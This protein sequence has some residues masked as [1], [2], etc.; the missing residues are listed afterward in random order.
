M[1]W[2]LMS[3]KRPAKQREIEHNLASLTGFLGKSGDEQNQ[4]LIQSRIDDLSS[5][6]RDAINAEER[7][8][9]MFKGVNNIEDLQKKIDDINNNL[10]GFSNAALRKM[11]LYKRLENTTYEEMETA[12]LQTILGSEEVQEIIDEDAY[13]KIDAFVEE[14]AEFVSKTQKGKKI[15]KS[16]LKSLIVQDVNEEK[17][18]RIKNRRLKGYQKNLQIMLKKTPKSTYSTKLTI[19]TDLPE[20]EWGNNI[21]YYPYAYLT[22]KQKQQAKD[23]GGVKRAKTI[24]E[25]FVRRLAGCAG[26]YNNEAEKI[27]STKFKP[28]DFFVESQAQFVGIL[29]EV[30][31]T[32]ILAVLVG[33]TSKVSFFGNDLENSKKIGVDVALGNVGFQVKNYNIEPW[34]GIQLRETITMQNFLNKMLNAS[35]SS[36]IINNLG[37]FYALR[38]YHV[39]ATE[40]F[41][42]TRQKIEQLSANI[43]AWLQSYSTAF[44]PLDT[45]HV[46]GLDL[47]NIFYF[48][49]GKRIV[50][51][52]YIISLYIDYLER[53]K[54]E[55]Y[56][57]N[58]RVS[59]FR[60]QYKGEQTYADYYAA[61][62]EL[63]TKH[64]VDN[65]V[66]YKSVFDQL[67][68]NVTLKIKLPPIQDLLNT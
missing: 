37:T 52:S 14:F 9:K 6:K 29:G 41:A 49:G 46:R 65:F 7:A 62:Q 26:K 34:E 43:S 42:D 16:H 17:T 68:M 30:Q 66:G 45:F 51:I 35:V 63:D 39:Q 57:A 60:P 15:Q 24:W 56:Q 55:G 23:I 50:P 67:D 10:I 11:P 48:I 31:T 61:Q 1:A 3:Y 53:L 12:L 21:N 13:Q 20:E 25:D 33:D 32:I 27:I 36:E 54:G 5:M 4:A 8:Y 28:E 19:Y 22:E 59:L 40:E 18:L 58:R 2:N 44:L 38:A 47:S 64:E